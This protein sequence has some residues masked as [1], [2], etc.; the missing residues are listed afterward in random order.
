[1]SFWDRL[2]RQQEF[3]LKTIDYRGVVTFRIPESWK[4]E[5]SD[6]EGGT[7][8]AD[9]PGS[10]TL[11]LMLISA[12]M[13]EE[14]SHKTAY[15]SLRAT[16]SVPAPAE[17][18]PN[19]NALARFERASLDQGHRVKIIFW[20]VNNAVPP[21]KLRTANFSYAFLESQSEDKRI[22]SEIALLDQE[23]RGAT[24]API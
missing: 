6:M 10:G 11:R 20:I 1:M 5:Y 3:K 24:I 18:L 16:K 2:S 8:Y 22:L 15:E 23:I 14:V 19:G 21:R 17:A 13:P 4:E 12:I 7:F 9:R